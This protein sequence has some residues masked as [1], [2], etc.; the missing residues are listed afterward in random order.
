MSDLVGDLARYGFLQNALACGLLASVAAGVVGSYVVVRRMTYLAGSIAHFVLGGMG[1]ARYLDR[2]CGWHWLS[3]LHG[4]LVAAVAAAVVVGWIGLRARE[5][6]DTVI[7][8]LWAIGMAVGI[9]FISRT[10]GYDEDLTS[11]L[12]G[13]ILMVSEGQLWLL[14]GLDAVI[15]ALGV[16]FHN[17]LVAVC[18]DEEFARLRGV[19]VDLF[20]LMLL[21]ATAL[22][23]VVLITVVG[24]V[25][26]IALLTI[27][28]AIAGQFCSKLWQTMIAAVAVGAALT[29][30]GLGVSYV[31]G[32]PPGATIILIAG[33]AYLASLAA[34]AGLRRARAA[35][36]SRS[37]DRP[38]PD[39]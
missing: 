26:V 27:P 12:F 22:T 25:M 10:P 21:V 14:A 9:L 37:R 3:P 13:N 38:G 36:A 32:A 17:Q 15:L 8:A 31:Q 20:Y 4:A 7:G 1:A 39:R 2:V 29:T 28:A 33:G 18:F 11:Y 6:E 35:S 24:I 16:A 23:V 5:R 34:R 30:V 19:P